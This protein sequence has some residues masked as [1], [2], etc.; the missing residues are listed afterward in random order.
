MEKCWFW[1]FWTKV[2]K[3]GSLDFGNF[4][5]LILDIWSSNFEHLILFQGYFYKAGH[6]MVVILA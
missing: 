1:K 5:N 2:L 4:E 3:V 6:Q